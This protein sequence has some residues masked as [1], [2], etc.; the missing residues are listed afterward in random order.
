[1]M[2]RPSVQAVIVDRKENKLLLIK[3]LDLIRKRYLWRLVKGGVDEGETEEQALKREIGEEV[4][5]KNIEIV[6]KIYEYEYEFK[7]RKFTVSAY[8]VKADMSEKIVLQVGGKES[9]I[10]DYKWVTKEEALE[11]LYWENEK[12][13]IKLLK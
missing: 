3:K 13:A 11:M 12:E 9:P 5:L 6:G 10:V 1:M 8:L 2:V 7:P 4:G